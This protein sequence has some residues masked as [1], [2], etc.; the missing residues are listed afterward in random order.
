[1]KHARAAIPEKR[2]DDDVAM[3]RPEGRDAAAVSG[4][5]RNRHQI[6]EMRDEQLFRRIADLGGIIHHQCLGVDMFQDMGGRDVAHVKGRV[7][8]HQHHIGIAAKVQLLLRAEAVVV[9]I[10]APE[11]DGPRPGGHAPAAQRQI[12]DMVMPELMAARLRFQHQGEG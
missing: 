6:R 10:F 8:A 4:H 3:L 7:L 1:M 11:R 12:T 5:H 9:A 2:L